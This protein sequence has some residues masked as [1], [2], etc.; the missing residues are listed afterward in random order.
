M[1]VKPE[2]ASNQG[3][4]LDNFADYVKQQDIFISPL[5]RP[6]RFPG[7]GL[8]I[9]A[10]VSIPPKTRLMHM[11]TNAVV[12]WSDIPRGFMPSAPPP[13][14]AGGMRVHSRLA[15]WLA[16]DDDAKK[17]HLAWMATWPALED[18][19]AGMPVL[20]P[21][22]CQEIR[23]PGAAQSKI[24]GSINGAKK[25]KV[26]KTQESRGFA[27]LPSGI[28]GRWATLSADNLDTP[29]GLLAPQQKKFEGDL[30]AATEYFPELEDRSSP[31]FQKFLHAWCC[32]NTRCF[33]Y[34]RTWPI[35]KN[36]ASKPTAPPEPPE[37][38]DEAMAMCPGMDFFNHTSDEDGGLCCTVDYDKDGYTVLSPNV[39]VKEG[40]EL[41]ISYGAH[42]EETLWVEYG[43]MLGGEK[44]QWDSV[45][46]DTVVFNDSRMTDEMR[47]KLKDA[48]YEGE[49]TLTRDGVCWRTETAARLLVMKAEQ[50]VRFIE[51]T[52]ADDHDEEQEILSK[53]AV[54]QVINGWILT[55]QREAENSLRGLE[56]LTP[57]ESL[58]WFSEV[59][60]SHVR[61]TIELVSARK[62][63]CLT[64]WRQLRE[65]CQDALAALNT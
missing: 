28:T 11:P 22:R 54:D 61:G 41:F 32:V 56:A 43:F 4:V 57:A 63:M 35:R 27:I 3:H 6:H 21:E 29:T 23:P 37:D 17:K 7:R 34:W 13:A 31:Q 48:E 10:E 2:M 26:Q 53:K 64:R 39:K 1:P 15:S 62:E 30:A 49:Y 47:T 42:S 16:F 59:E 24:N 9:R 33:Y 52:Y 38:R 58:H 45:D 5:I 14:E 18:F 25:R 19:K 65:I 40:E 46:I 12:K 60:D 44:N 55:V 50:W 8:G 20:W 36:G 51:G